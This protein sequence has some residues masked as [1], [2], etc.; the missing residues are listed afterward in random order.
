[1]I[2]KKS[3]VKNIAE[4]SKLNQAKLNQADRNF[5]TDNFYGSLETREE[6]QYTSFNSDI[7]KPNTLLLCFS[8]LGSIYGDISTSPLYTL[9]G[10]FSDQPTEN[11]I[12]GA[13]SIIFYLFTIIV[14]F[15][16]VLLVLNLGSYEG[17]GGHLAIFKKVTSAKNLGA[18]HF[19]LKGICLLGCSLVI[20]DGL[21]TPSTSIL[22]AISGLSRPIPEFNHV[23]SVSVG[24][25]ILLSVVQQFGA[26]R[27]SFLFAPIIFLWLVC[28]FALGVFNIYKAP[29]ILKALNPYYGLL[30]IQNHGIGCLTSA[31]LAI[32]GCEA[33]F[34]DLGLFR[35]QLPI[36]L[37]LTFFVYPCLMVNYLGQCSFL[38]VTSNGTEGN[39]FYN[40]IS[41]PGFVYWITFVL[42]TLST[43]IASQA[44]ILGVFTIIKQ[45]AELNIFPKIK[46]FHFH[47]HMVYI[48]SVNYVLMGGI[49]CTVLLFRNPDKI[50]LAYGLGISIDF[51]IT[52]VLMV[53][54]LVVVYESFWAIFFG[55]IFI[56]LEM[57]LVF[58]NLS[59]IKDGGW[60]TVVVSVIFMVYLMKR[61][62][63]LEKRVSE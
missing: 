55:L 53:V 21:L 56:P 36:Q 51:L 33:L 40:S 10:M 29:R 31:T 49:I 35:S 61:V 38:L 43:I 60:F 16:Y 25:I 32:T 50:T 15:K 59:K 2:V 7:K 48:P 39:I 22:N 47:K 30:F 37:T 6:T 28:I 41:G 24:I 12:C 4:L 44:L 23:V 57:V 46:I 54:T 19:W 14:I 34:L 17:E 63:E 5:T 11:D 62:R 20:A 1:M 18:K 9:N 58:E 3:S 52:S 45:L 13:M 8:S 42:A 27:I 26:H